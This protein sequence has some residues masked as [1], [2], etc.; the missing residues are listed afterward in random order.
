MASGF[1]ALFDD[2]A[3]VL[4]DLAA[5]TKVAATKTAGVTGD[6]LAVGANQLTGFASSR[7]LPVV[8]KVAKGSLI[9]K[10]ILIPS[11]LGISALGGVIG[12][13]LIAPMLMI[14]G[15]YLCYEGM[16]KLT[17]HKSKHDADEDHKKLME[18][19]NKGNLLAFENKKIKGAIQTDLVLS[20][21]I[22]I[23]TLGTMANAPLATQAAVMSAIGIGMTGFVYGLV[24]GIVK[25]DD[26]GFM[27]LKKAGD[28][29]ISKAVRGLG[30]GLVNASPKLMKTLSI[31]GT[32]AMFL[33]GGQIMLHNV[34]AFSHLVHDLPEL[35]MYGAE[36]IAGLATGGVVLGGVKGAS[37]IAG[38]IAKVIPAPVKEKM[39]KGARQLKKLSP[40]RLLKKKRPLKT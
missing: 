35:A 5:M 16:E 18:A 8:A 28:N 31:V 23:L 17:H 20:A 9:N 19:A 10:V 40:S 29:P 21:E 30:K 37:G 4:D 6:D 13:D 26:L 2:I 11:I 14:G 15:G 24:A 1:F 27:L 33:V 25:M 7:E 36:I 34:P 32:V 39:S 12:V 3:T 22:L 38:G